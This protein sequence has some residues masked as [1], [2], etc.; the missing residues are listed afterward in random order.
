MTMKQN[1][2]VVFTYRFPPNIG[3][4]EQGVFE[5][6][7]A[8]TSSGFEVTVYAPKCSGCNDHD[9][10]C[11]FPIIRMPFTDPQVS[12]EPSVARRLVRGF[13]GMFFLLWRGIRNKLAG[14]TEQFLL[15]EALSQE[16]FGVISWLVPINPIVTVNVPVITQRTLL[17]E[18]IRAFFLL[19]CYKR[20]SV[21]FC[22]SQ[23]VA[24]RLKES[25]RETSLPPIKVLGYA[26][27]D[28][29]LDAPYQK[30]AITRI[31]SELGI[32]NEKVI[33]TVAQLWKEKGIDNVIRS[34]PDVLNHCKSRVKYI[35]VGAGPDRSYLEQLARAEDVAEHVI[36]VGA[37][38][39]EVTLA[40]FDLCD[41]FVMPSRLN[42]TFG[43]VFIEASSRGKPVIGGKIGGQTETIADGK[44]GLL[45]DPYNVEEIGNKIAR[46]LNDP[47]L[48]ARLGENGKRLVREKFSRQAIAQRFANNL[49]SRARR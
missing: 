6:V 1:R 48:A 38:P 31:K 15:A 46:L 18:R 8:L 17:S 9:K 29:F 47:I 21:I 33:L 12:R 40:Y 27:S 13:V 30:E 2:I 24:R 42:E 20:A 22:A 41:I 11:P 26:V 4:I 10:M 5:L 34:L 14:K 28:A 49:S 23:S 35:I 32:T 16:V 7:E 45:V 37:V 25:L 36:F 3:G 39:H 19:Q 43:I 44:T